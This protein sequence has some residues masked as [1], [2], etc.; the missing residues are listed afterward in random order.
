MTLLLL[1]SFLYVSLTAKGNIQILL[2]VPLCSQK[3]NMS[4]QLERF[5][6]PCMAGRSEFHTFEA[7]QFDFWQAYRKLLWR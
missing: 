1:T 5:P 3:T 7:K 2:P 4:Q 6:S